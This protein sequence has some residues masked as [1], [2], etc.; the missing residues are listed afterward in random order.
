MGPSEQLGMIQMVTGGRTEADMDPDLLP[1]TPPES[2]GTGSG[3]LWS[4]VPATK[5]LL[6]LLFPP[7]RNG[8]PRQDTQPA[9]LPGLSLG[10]LHSHQGG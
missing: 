8:A 9:R 10:L 2:Q 7:Q 4:W 1:P 3:L 6:P 5:A